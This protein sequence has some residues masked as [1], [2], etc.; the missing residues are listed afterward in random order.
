MAP[1]P[2][3][4]TTWRSSFF[5]SAATAMPNAAEMELEAWPQTKES[6]SLSSGEGNGLMP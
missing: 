1:S 3:T 5:I 4:A 6:Y 2:M